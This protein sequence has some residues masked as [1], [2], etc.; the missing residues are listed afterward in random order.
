MAARTRKKTT[1]RKTTRRKTTRRKSPRTTRTRRTAKPTDWLSLV[2]PQLVMEALDGIGKPGRTSE[3]KARL[4]TASAAVRAR[5]LCMNW[6]AE[7]QEIVHEGA[8]IRDSIAQGILLLCCAH[9]AKNIQDNSSQ[10]HFSDAVQILRAAVDQSTQG[11]IGNRRAGCRQHIVLRCAGQLARSLRASMRDPEK[12]HLY[13][14][15]I[16]RSPGMSEGEPLCPS[17]EELQTALQ[18]L[19]QGIP[20]LPQGQSPETA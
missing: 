16:H 15:R 3:E 20:S 18:L 14:D 5:N 13:R 11:G 4:L 9:H 6:D 19:A 17:D 8:E 2:S 10:R 7:L 12:F 1:R